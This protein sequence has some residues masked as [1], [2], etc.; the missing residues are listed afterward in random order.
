MKRLFLI[1]TLGLL[2]VSVSAQ[3]TVL[4]SGITWYVR[5]GE[6]GPGPNFWSDSPDNVW[7][8]TEGQLHLKIRKEGN[9][10]YCSEVYAQKS[11]GYGE[12]RFYIN[13]NVENLDPLTVVGLFT[14]ETDTREIDIEFSRWGNPANTDGWYTVQP[15]IPGNQLSFA[16]NLTGSQSTHKFTWSSNSILFQS[17]RGYSATLP[18]ADSLI[19][20]WNYTGNNIPP[21][22]NERVHINFWLMGGN[23]P[24]N[25]QD[26]ELVVKS[27]FVPSANSI[28]H[29][30]ARRQM[31]LYPTL[32]TD[33]ITL[34]IT[35]PSDNSILSIINT[36][37]QLIMRQRITENKTEIDVRNLPA[38][39]FFVR[40]VQDNVVEVQ[41]I[42]RL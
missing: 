25:L 36:N 3:T 39:V 37:G 41:K 14:Y 2:F 28:Y 5:S 35:N 4:F 8:D 29:S 34:E 26:A 1:L 30:D 33:R 27:V 11:F 40:L 19:N 17:Y 21:V 9:T 42:I 24:A 38:G 15:V 20:E 7:V 31:N 10:W 16:L 12:Y 13:S 6:G 23:T 18:S 22:G 32:Y